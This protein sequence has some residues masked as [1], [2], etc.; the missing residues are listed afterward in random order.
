MF[1]KK[2][3]FLILISALCGFLK[4]QN[5]SDSLVGVWQDSKIVASG[6]SNTFLFFK[7][8]EF[9]FFYNQ[10]DCAKR[11]V[12]FSGEWKA[13]GDELQL[14]VI[15]K[16]IIKGGTLEPS[17]GS[18]ASDSMIV[19]GVEQT[20]KSKP[21]EM[22]IYSISQIYVDK[23]DDIQRSKIYID[24][25]NFWKFSDYPYEMLKQFEIEK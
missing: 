5:L 17:E 12:S 10:M 16:N 19:G 14:K 15:Q 3:I 6:W 4:S 20:V 18:C 23:E 21:P 22:L 1:S 25:I 11:E 8:G 13:G 7:N 9:K 24:A 2:F